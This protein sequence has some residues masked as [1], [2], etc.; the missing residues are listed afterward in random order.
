MTT[1]IATVSDGIR[2]LDRVAP[3]PELQAHLTAA[4]AIMARLSDDA[5][6][7]WACYLLEELETL[8]THGAQPLRRDY[9]AW[10]RTVAEAISDRV[11][12]GSW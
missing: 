12:S 4:A 1:M 11:T 6:A 8:R 7:G 5:R 3:L 10:L 9:D 2:T